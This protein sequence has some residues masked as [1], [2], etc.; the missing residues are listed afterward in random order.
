MRFRLKGAESLPRLD[1]Q[2]EFELY[3]ICLELLNNIIKHARA[4]EG[5]IDLSQANGNLNLNVS[6]NGSGHQGKQAEGLGMQN[7]AARVASLGGTWTVEANPEQGIQN[8]IVVP[9]RTPARAS[10]RT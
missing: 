4:T 3:S 9:V 2:T 8:K 1:H 7:V 10:S 6:D 5:H